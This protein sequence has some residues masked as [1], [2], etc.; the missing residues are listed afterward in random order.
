[1]KAEQV[2][3]LLKITRPTLCSYIRDHKI[4]AIKL[5]NGYYD[6]DDNSVYQFLGQPNPDSFKINVIYARVST[7]KQK[8]DLGNQVLQLIDFCNSRN[9]KYGKV[10]QEIASGIDFDRSQ[11]SELI[12]LVMAGKVEN[13]YVTYKDRISRLSFITLQNLFKFFGTNIIVINSSTNSTNND[14]L[15]EELMNII[16]LFSTKLYS[17]RRKN[18]KTSKN[19]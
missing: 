2:L 9:I 17:H 10:F 5:P 19:I 3:K 8:N 14:D 15:F 1:M 11:F 13:I 6:Y 4:K 7:Y 12:Q 16:H 18:K